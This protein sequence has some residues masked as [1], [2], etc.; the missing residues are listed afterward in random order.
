MQK[1]E[2]DDGQGLY[3]TS[4]MYDDSMMTKIKILM[5]K[6]LFEMC[7]HPLLLKSVKIYMN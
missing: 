1:G 7:V 3:I 4:S 6:C 2:G 5:K